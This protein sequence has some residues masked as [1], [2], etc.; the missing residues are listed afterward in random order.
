MEGRLR[1]GGTQWMTLLRWKI[2][3]ML[4]DL[5]RRKGTGKAGGGP[6]SCHMKKEGTYSAIQAWDWGPAF[7]EGCF[8]FLFSPF[9]FPSPWRFLSVSVVPSLCSFTYILPIMPVTPV[10][11]VVGFG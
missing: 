4:R 6:C 11:S 9:L 8:C 5:K 1:A 7:L 3:V 10:V 2:G